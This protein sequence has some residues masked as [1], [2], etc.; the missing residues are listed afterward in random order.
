VFSLAGLSGIFLI[1]LSFGKYQ[2][3]GV[4]KGLKVGEFKFHVS[5]ENVYLLQF[6]F[7]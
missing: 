1:N 5:Y 7:E 2:I 6:T 3:S 4:G